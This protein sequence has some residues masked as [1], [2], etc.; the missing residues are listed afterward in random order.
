MIR[1]SVPGASLDIHPEQG[2]WIS[3]LVLD[4]TE[5]LY[6]H[7]PPPPDDLPGGIPI[8]Y[9]ICG[10][11]LAD[12]PLPRHGYAWRLPWTPEPPP[13]P[14]TVL[15]SL[16][17]P[18]GALLTLRA[19]LAPRHFSLALAIKGQTPFSLHPHPGFHPYFLDIGSISVP[20]PCPRW[21]YAPD[22]V[23]LLPGP[24][25]PPPMPLPA[26]SPLQRDLLLQAS[27]ALLHRRD[28]K[29]L[30]LA[31]TPGTLPFLQFYADFRHPFLAVEPW[32]APAGA[33]APDAPF[34]PAPLA[35]GATRTY[36]FTLDLA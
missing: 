3:S 33:T 36:G 8:L 11:P 23:H 4:G 29:T 28:G 21:Q 24:L 17:S 1:L 14:D 27:T 19:S 7:A 10:R 30:H 18:D 6:V 26:S 5:L 35:P 34:R 20:P 15:L 32:S 31:A 22:Y 13:A 12:S 9:P 25:P 2:A 16:S